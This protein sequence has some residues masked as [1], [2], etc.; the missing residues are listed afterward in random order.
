M[1]KTWKTSLVAMTAVALMLAAGLVAGCSDGSDGATTTVAAMTAAPTTATSAA[2]SVTTAPAAGADD[3]VPAGSA[4]AGHPSADVEAGSLSQEEQEA[5]LFLR[6]E[7]KLAHDVYVTLYEKWG[8]QVFDNI[9]RS[10]LRHMDSMKG[11]LDNYGLAD[12]IGSNELGVFTD[13][14]L[15][16]LF[17]TL[18]AQGSESE[19]E[20]LEAG[21]AVETKDIADLEELIALTTHSD[22]KEV[23]Q[24]LLDGSR[25]HLAAFSRRR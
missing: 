1:Q 14:E 3:G 11:L 6:E 7:E 21:I 17:D 9:S 15:Q 16:E 8:T 18:V 12:P 23:A 4:D 10:E 5:L 19:V 22:I 13:P 2:A 25:K 20:A 24:N